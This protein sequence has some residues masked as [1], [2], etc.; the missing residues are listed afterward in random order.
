M[1][2]VTLSEWTARLM[3][4]HKKPVNQ[5]KSP[6]N[7][8]VRAFFGINFYLDDAMMFLFL[9]IEVVPFESV[10]SNR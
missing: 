3:V 4:D 8:I 10:I 2:G 1:Q 5:K 7:L 6:D 9:I